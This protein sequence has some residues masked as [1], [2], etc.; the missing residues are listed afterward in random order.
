MVKPIASETKQNKRPC[1]SVL[2]KSVVVL[3]LLAL[4]ISQTGCSQKPEDLINKSYLVSDAEF[5]L[6]T[7][8]QV[9]IYAIDGQEEGKTV[10]SDD[11]AIKAASERLRYATRLRPRF[12]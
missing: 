2:R 3:L 9:T 12:C 5:F 11:E 1:F 10:L 6:D 8:C 7:V 4:I